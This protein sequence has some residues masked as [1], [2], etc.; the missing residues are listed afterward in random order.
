MRLSWTYRTASVGPLHLG[1][2]AHFSVEHVHLLH[3]T[4][5]SRFRGLTHLLV[6]TLR[7]C[8]VQDKEKVTEPLAVCSSEMFSL[9]CGADLIVV[10]RRVIAQ[11]AD[12][13]QLNQSIIL[14]TLDG[15][16]VLRTGSKPEA[17]LLWA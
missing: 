16:A 7:L 13:R 14:G 1:K 9:V 15:H 5:Q 17:D 12:G 8:G 11:S 6:N 10:Q 3:Q 2:T 4:A